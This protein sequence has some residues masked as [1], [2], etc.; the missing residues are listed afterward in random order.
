MIVIDAV[1]RNYID[2]P[3]IMS[4]FNYFIRVQLTICQSPPH[5][6]VNKGKAEKIVLTYHE[7]TDTVVVSGK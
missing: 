4:G 1:E 7:N 5:L 2:A 3:E 6:R